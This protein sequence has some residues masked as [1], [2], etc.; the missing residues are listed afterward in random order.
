MNP[1]RVEQLQVQGHRGEPLVAADHGR[2]P[3]QVIID[4]VR[5]VV[6]R[7]PGRP[8]TGLEDDRVVAVALDLTLAADR[9]DEPGRL[10]SVRGPE[11]DHVGSPFGQAPLAPS[12]GS[13]SRHS[14][15]LP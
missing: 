3:H 11:P 8:I 10:G 15:Q 6:G 2:D 7:Q 4:G 12:A 5:E 13:A 9:V 1:E 14:A